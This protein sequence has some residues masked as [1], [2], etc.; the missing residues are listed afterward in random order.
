MFSLSLLS[1]CSDGHWTGWEDGS[2]VLLAGGSGAAADPERDEK[3]DPAADGRQLD[4]PALLQHRH[5]KG[6]RRATHAQVQHI[7]E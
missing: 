2:A 6:G 4:P 5:Q 7:Q 3:E 1:G